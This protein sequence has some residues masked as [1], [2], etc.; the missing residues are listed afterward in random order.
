MGATTRSI[1]ANRCHNCDRL[2]DMMILMQEQM[3]SNTESI[4]Q[5][6]KISKDTRSSMDTGLSE[7]QVD[8]SRS[9]MAILDLINNL[10]LRDISKRLATFL[11]CL[12][13]REDLEN[14]MS[15]PGIRRIVDE[16]MRENFNS[17][18]IQT[19][20][21]NISNSVP[22][23]ESNPSVVSETVDEPLVQHPENVNSN[24]NNV[25]TTESTGTNS[26]NDPNWNT[27]QPK[28][29]RKKKNN[30]VA[31]ST[32]PTSQQPAPRP[33]PPQSASTVVAAA[34]SNVNA[35]RKRQ[36]VGAA[37]KWIFVTNL[38]PHLT[39]ADMKAHIVHKCGT[40]MNNVLCEMLSDRRKK[41]DYLS[42]KVSL[43]KGDVETLKK[44]WP[45]GVIAR[46]F[47]RGKQ[48]FRAQQTQRQ[49]RR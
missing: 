37:R 42:F 45:T 20:L 4:R 48:G 25:D 3:N 47:T 12:E 27:V 9:E 33:P 38:K 5:L 19:E 14:T 18:S 24:A 39:V 44:I 29:R 31:T 6:I 16:A 43:E 10:K 34:P 7:I 11:E 26:E 15:V 46:N 23:P 13:N 21:H 2:A 30:N 35:T 1:E 41:N 36:I 17:S 49:S 8:V 40:N 22:T 28:R 32:N